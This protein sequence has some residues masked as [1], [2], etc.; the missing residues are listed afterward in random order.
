MSRRQVLMMRPSKRIFQKKPQFDDV[1]EEP[2]VPVNT[3]TEESVLPVEQEIPSKEEVVE[4]TGPEEE[5]VL[6]TSEEAVQDTE[7]IENSEQVEVSQEENSSAEQQEV[8]S[9]PEIVVPSENRTKSI[10][11][12]V[13]I[14]SLQKKTK[15]ELLKMC[16]ELGFEQ[17]PN[18]RQKT[19]IKVIAQH[20][21]L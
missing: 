7:Q 11:P 14:L 13:T 8:V 17:N 21:G 20:L 1:I 3:N 16:S 10:K 5:V 4:E 19:L 6:E 18:L 9:A 15:D 12:D 2:D